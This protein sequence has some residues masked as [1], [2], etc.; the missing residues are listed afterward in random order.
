MKYLK[1]S[2]HG[3]IDE[4]AFS[5]VGATSKRNDSAKIGMFGSGLKY[6]LAYLLNNRIDFRI[7]SGYR[8]V[9]F[10][11]K[12]EGFRGI[13]VH[14]IYVNGEKTSLTTDMGIDWTHWYVLREIYCNALDEQDGTIRLI[15]VQS[16]D[17]LV[18]VE[19]YTCFYI[20]VDEGFQEVLD[21]WN[22]YFSDSRKDL[23]WSDSSGNKI[24]TGGSDSLIYRKGIRAFYVGSVSSLFHYDLTWVKINESRVIA[25][26]FDFK[27]HLVKFLK[28]IDDDSI[29]HR[30]IYN[31]NDYSEKM[32]YWHTSSPFSDAYMRVI[33]NKTLIPYENAGFWADEIKELKTSHII[34][35]NE[36]INGL[37]NSFGDAIN[38]IGESEKGSA[39]SDM[40][41]VTNLGKRQKKLLDESVAFLQDAGYNLQYEVKIVQFSNPDIH[42]RAKDETIFVSEKVLSLGRK[43]IVA[44]LIEENEHLRSGH[45]DETRAFQ[46]HLI[47]LFICSLE[48]KSEKYL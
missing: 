6:S 42:G 35:P 48:D 30:I 40:K 34:L 1:I 29:A 41:P 31:I 24:Y 36:M 5:L 10:E 11:T 7:Y 16:L 37:K 15:D 25:N 14:R 27:F 3:E 18:P 32:L 22:A 33:G 45:A 28:A 47:N 4:R 21:N 39:G 26:E 13:S 38:V 8:E 23:I 19:D 43:E 9:K 44:T 46:N 2:S 20:R 17:E 12:E